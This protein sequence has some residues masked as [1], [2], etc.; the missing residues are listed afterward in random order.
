[1][2]GICRIFGQQ[3]RRL[4]H[5]RTKWKINVS[6]DKARRSTPRLVP[7]KNFPEEPRVCCVRARCSDRPWQRSSS[8]FA[9]VVCVLRERLGSEVSRPGPSLQLDQRELPCLLIDGEEVP[10][11]SEENIRLRMW[12]RPQPRTRQAI[13][14]DVASVATCRDSKLAN[15]WVARRM[16]GTNVEPCLRWFEYE[17]G[18]APQQLPAF[19]NSYPLPSIN[20]ALSRDLSV[21]TTAFRQD[22]DAVII[23]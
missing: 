8:Q 23:G 15:Q 6:S 17:D 3:D 21:I 13:R 1:M 2:H 18:L 4:D 16:S 10:S 9:D 11:T 19:F 14:D 22:S 5:G 20:S 12:R 7:L